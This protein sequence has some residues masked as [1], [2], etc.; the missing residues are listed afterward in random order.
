MGPAIYNCPGLTLDD[1]PWGKWRP[2]GRYYDGSFDQVDR[3]FAEL[4]IG[5]YTYMFFEWRSGAIECER[6]AEPEDIEVFS[7]KPGDILLAQCLLIELTK[8]KTVQDPNL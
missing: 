3:R 6:L 1:L 2:G 4:L 7:T 5:G 8:G